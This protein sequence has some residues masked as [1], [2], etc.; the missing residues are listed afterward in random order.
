MRN[1]TLITLSIVLLLPVA[2]RAEEAVDE[3]LKILKK[4]T[5]TI[6]ELVLKSKTEE[7]MQDNVKDLMDQFV[8]FRE[9][10]ELSLGSKWKT[11]TEEQQKIYLVQFRELLQR[12]YLR[13]FKPGKEFAVK[14]RS[15][16]RF[17]KQR[18]R[19][20]IQT[21]IIS[22]DVE[23]DVDYRFSNA[24]GWKVYD[25]VV[26]EVSIMR[27][28]RKSFLRILKKDG[29]EALIEKMKKKTSDAPEE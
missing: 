21:T 10:G 18:V 20:E 11:L 24:D 6:R 12:T 7:E 29:F 15:E 16:T 14:Y 19:G 27:N 4:N 9:F 13:R 25:M 1:L 2:L 26:D 8:N 23:A 5:E 28:Y 22:G 3:P 17:N